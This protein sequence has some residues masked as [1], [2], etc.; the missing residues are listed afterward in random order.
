[1][2]KAGMGLAL[3]EGMRV[4]FTVSI[5]GLTLFLAAS[6]SFA[7]K[8]FFPLDQKA[9]KNRTAIIEK[10]D[11]REIRQQRATRARSSRFMPLNRTVAT[12][13]PLLRNRTESRQ[14]RIKLASH[15]ETTPM[16]AADV[17]DA[18]LMLYGSA[19]IEDDHPFNK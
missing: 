19:P 7:A 10:L 18:V 14:D 17:S 13:R 3:I 2:A 6:N 1:M 5:M 8:K 16:M 4:F 12:V 9:L 11:E 15:E